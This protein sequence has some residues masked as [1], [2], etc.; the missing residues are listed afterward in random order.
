M[1]HPLDNPVWSSLVSHHQGFALGEGRVR[2]YREDVA[3][4]A[5]MQ[6]ASPEA[7]AQLLELIPVGGKAAMVGVL[8]TLGSNWRVDDEFMGVQMVWLGSSPKISEGTEIQ[9]LNSADVPA[10]L[11]LTALVYPAYFRTG[12][13]ELGDYLAIR[14]DRALCAMAGIRMSMPGFQE[15]SA[16][17]VHPYFQGKGYAGRL[18]RCLVQ[19]ILA[20]G[21]IPFLHT[22]SENVGARG[23]YQHLGFSERG[24]V[25]VRVMTRI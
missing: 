15:I 1:S 4:F 8:P 25:P 22:E 12:T 16:V 5:A 23:M 9:K 19:Q 3:P 20:S 6:D 2:R 24:L 14:Q 13:A 18:M 7:E 21:N 11:D 17:C 10:M